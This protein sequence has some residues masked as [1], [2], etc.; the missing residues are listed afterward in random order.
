MADATSVDRRSHQA[1]S[2]L[3]RCIASRSAERRQARPKL[4]LYGYP[5]WS[6]GRVH[7]E[8]SK[9]LA[10][11]GYVVDLLD[12]QQ[13]HAANIEALKGYY[14]LVM[15]PPDGVGTLVDAYGV[16]RGAVGRRLITTSFDIRMLI[17]RNE[18]DI[19]DRVSAY[20]VVSE[21][22]VPLQ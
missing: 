14:D 12:W 7:Y 22:S 17:E 5:R 1:P 11:L 3:I 10:R 18:I 9:R 20:A 4:L 8:I 21:P 15:S 2:S 19:F 13:D 16:P 6:H